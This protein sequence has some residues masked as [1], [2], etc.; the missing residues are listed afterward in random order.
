MAVGEMLRIEPAV[1]DVLTIDV[2]KADEVED[3]AMNRAKNICN[4]RCIYLLP[5]FS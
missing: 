4:R 1:G 2:A 5:T 3:R